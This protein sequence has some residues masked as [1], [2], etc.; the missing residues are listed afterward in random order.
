MDAVQAF[1]LDLSWIFFIAWGMVLAAVGAIT[2]GRDF[3][4]PASRPA[5][6]PETL[7][8]QGH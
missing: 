5:Y 1:V 2:F 7:S 8:L 4:P 3:F 6:E